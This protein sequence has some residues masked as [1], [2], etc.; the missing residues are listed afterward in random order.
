[1]R[2][3]LIV[4][5]LCAAGCGQAPSPQTD[6]GSPP[7][8]PAQEAGLPVA[9][10]PRPAPTGLYT[11]EEI[12]KIAKVEIDREAGAFGLPFDAPI[13]DVVPA[14]ESRPRGEVFAELGIKDSRVRNFWTSGINHVTF[15]NWQVSPSYDISCMTGSFDPDNAG[16]ELTDSRRKVYGIRLILHPK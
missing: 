7:P 2:H 9:P 14:G 8:P 1:M 10:A 5:V 3:T 13:L 4:V 6:P 15:L 11:D 12:R 16:L